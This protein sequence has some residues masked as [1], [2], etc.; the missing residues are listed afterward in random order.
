MHSNMFSTSHQTATQARSSP[1]LSQ[2]QTVQQ[3]EHRLVEITHIAMQAPKFCS[4]QHPLCPYHL[5]FSLPTAVSFY[6]AFT[7]AP[8]LKDFPTLILSLCPL[9]Y[10]C[11]L[12]LY[13]PTAPRILELGKTI[14]Q[15]RG[16]SHHYT[17]KISL[18][19]APLSI[20]TEVWG[21][22]SIIPTFGTLRTTVW[23]KSM[24]SSNHGSHFSRETLGVCSLS[25]CLL[26]LFQSISIP[27]FF[28]PCEHVLSAAV[29]WEG[30]ENTST[31]LPQ[32]GTMSPSIQNT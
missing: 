21:K 25:L 30:R 19:S 13:P 1:S 20:R 27:S 24:F 9:S 32:R 5:P 8:L 18:D 26:L 12:E 3:P 2:S 16:F 31:A 7:Q 14:R 10:L 17:P 29:S 15:C 4:T 6:P 22:P 11:L 23:L 28:S